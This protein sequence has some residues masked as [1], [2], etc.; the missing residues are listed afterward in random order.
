MEYHVELADLHSRRDRVA[1]QQL[2]TEYAADPAINGPG[3]TRTVVDRV[4]TDLP[5]QSN[6]IVFLVRDRRGNAVGMATCFQTYST[7]AAAPVI[8]IHDVMVTSPLR[9]RGIG[10][11]LIRHILT[12]AADDSCAKV[13]LEVYRNNHAAMRL[14]QSMGFQVP[15]AGRDLGETLFLSCGLTISSS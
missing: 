9:G 5:K 3:L 1:F 12:A 13:T 10:Q 15:D 7:F 8:N 2:L 11:Q 14:Y 6:S 4:A